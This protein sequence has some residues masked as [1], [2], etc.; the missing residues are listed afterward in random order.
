MTIDSEPAEKVPTGISGLDP[1]A[2]GGLPRGSSTLV[3]GTTGTGKTLFAIEFLARGVADYSQPGVY[4]TFEEKAEDIRRNARRFGFPIDEWEREGLW[5]FV[6]GS[7]HLATETVTS[8]TYNYAALVSRVSSAIR[9]IS[10]ARVSLDSIGAILARYPDVATVRGE[11]LRFVSSLKELDVTSVLTAERREEHDGVSLLGTEEYVVDNVIVLRNL[12][13]AERRRRT[14]EIVKFRGAR[15]RT[16]E[17]L[18]TIDPG[19]GLVII[20]LAF[21][22]PRE[23][24][25]AV[26]VSTG[27][28]DLDQMCEGGVFKDAVILLTG[29][30]GAGKTLTGL[31]F[32]RAAYAS[33]ERCLFYTYDEPRD[34]LVRSAAGWGLDLTTME[35][36]G[37][38]RVVS[39]Y[40]EAAS[41]EDHFLSLRRNVE[42]FSPNR[43]VIDTLSALERIVTP[44]GLLDFV[45]A[46]GAVLREREITTLLTS[47][48][49]GRF[50][51]T[52]TP[53]IALESTSLADVGI[54]IRYV[55][56]AGNIQRAIAILQTR[57]S[58]HDS[59]V[60]QVT[61]E[62]GQGM[63][64]G[65]PLPHTA[66]LLPNE[67][68]M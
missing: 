12:L 17:W 62:A 54:N 19:E 8:G 38:L 28:P 27:T 56:H 34:R 64:I 48:P 42:E 9:R 4:V 1:I 43:L 10:A 33:G 26:R 11:L 24:A 7:D 37:L 6:D 55:E 66:H 32:A 41:L 18:F 14:I 68:G 46:L 67:G 30:T 5:A 47:A 61:M 50:T 3:T 45:I 57:G 2:L 65:D 29:P 15:H 20:P 31:M 53:A 59:A 16:G 39:V 36:S 51:S 60:R 49:S 23:E 58:G 25:S 35:E 13:H 44:R 22:A 63:R 52:I 40:P 21:L